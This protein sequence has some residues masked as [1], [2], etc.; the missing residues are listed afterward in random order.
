MMDRSDEVSVIEQK[1]VNKAK[2][3]GYA[4]GLAVFAGAVLWKF[5]VR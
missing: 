2:V 4:I 3:W 5:L 1:W